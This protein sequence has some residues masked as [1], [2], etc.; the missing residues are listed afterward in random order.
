MYLVVNPMDLALLRE[1]HSGK[2]STKDRWTYSWMFRVAAHEIFRVR[3][4]MV[5]SGEFIP[6]FRWPSRLGFFISYQKRLREAFRG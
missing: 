5:S 4:P 2:L 3:V 6:L 1:V